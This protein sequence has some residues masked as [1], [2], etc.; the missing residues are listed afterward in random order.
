MQKENAV[1][2]Y[3]EERNAA[4]PVIMNAMLRLCSQPVTKLCGLVLRR[5]QIVERLNRCCYQYQHGLYLDD[6]LDDAVSDYV[7]AVQS[8]R[9]EGKTPVRNPVNY[10]CSVI[11]SATDTYQ[12]LKWLEQR[13]EQDYI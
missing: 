2:Y 4:Y 10:A 9:D 7:N 13:E 5:E 3:D 11:W 8:R 6:F 12:R 1:F